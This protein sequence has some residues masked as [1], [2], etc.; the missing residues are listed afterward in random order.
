MSA[1]DRPLRWAV[2]HFSGRLPAGTGAPDPDPHRNAHGAAVS[3]KIGVIGGD[4][5]GPEVIGRGPQGRRAPP[6]SSSTRSTTTWAAPAT[7][8]TA[9]SCP[10]ACSTSG[11]GSTPCCSARS[12]PPRCRPGVI[13]RGLLLKM[14]FDLDL[15]I[16][17]RPVRRRRQGHRHGG[18]PRE[19]RGPLRRRGR[20]A[21]QGHA[22]RG[23][24]PGLGQH[25]HGRRAVRPLRL[26]PGRGRAAASTSRWCTRPTCSRSPATC[27][28]APS[29]RSPPSTPRSARPTTTSTR[30]A[31]TS[32]PTRSAT[33]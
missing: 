14:R 1:D 11:A 4:G 26:R 6:A 19:H 27:G 2:S 5:I 23:G 3:H 32:C 22:P 13:E 31:S 25:P 24:H 33:T 28:S 30:P 8:A 15:Y 20:R 7:C 29:T 21:A 9:R 10:T 18:D 16:N 12:A 17:Q